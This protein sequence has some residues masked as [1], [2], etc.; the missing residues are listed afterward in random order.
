M[1]KLKGALVEDGGGRLEGVSVEAK[2]KGQKGVIREEKG[3]ERS[4]C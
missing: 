2:I 1:V 3:M 4:A